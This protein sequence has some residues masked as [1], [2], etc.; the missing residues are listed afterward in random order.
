MR[1]F[2]SEIP[3][4]NLEETRKTIHGFATTHVHSGLNVVFITVST[5]IFL[6]TSIFYNVDQVIKYD[7]HSMHTPNKA[8]YNFAC[9]LLKHFKFILCM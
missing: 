9:I 7:R 1:Y 5:A 8:M 2:D 6:Y 3:P 4:T